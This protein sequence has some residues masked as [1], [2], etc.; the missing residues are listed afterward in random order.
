M[1]TQLIVPAHKNVPALPDQGILRRNWD[2]E[3][4]RSKKMR[5]REREDVW[6]QR[7]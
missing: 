2:I 3:K 1:G 6:M 4:L 7:K 5:K